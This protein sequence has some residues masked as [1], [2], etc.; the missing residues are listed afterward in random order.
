[1]R[2]I[3]LLKSFLKILTTMIIP[4]VW[5]D[6]VKTD[7]IAALQ[8]FMQNVLIIMTFKGHNIFVKTM[9]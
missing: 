9:E 7:I 3:V 4:S 5:G 1:M 6:M 2:T 8:D